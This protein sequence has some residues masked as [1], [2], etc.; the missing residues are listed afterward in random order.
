MRCFLEMNQLFE[1]TEEADRSVG[2]LAGKN[3]VALREVVGVPSRLKLKIEPLCISLISIKHQFR[4][5]L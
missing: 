5:L 1:R 4:Y 3:R 2:R